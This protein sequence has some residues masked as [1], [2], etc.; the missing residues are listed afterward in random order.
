VQEQACQ[1]KAAGDSDI[2][3]NQGHRGANPNKTASKTVQAGCKGDVDHA[4][5]DSSRM[6][7]HPEQ[8]P[9]LNVI[10]NIERLLESME[11]IERQSQ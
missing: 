5:H 11:K 10:R 1:E 4:Q 8:S 9:H 3:S 7:R 2:G 6:C